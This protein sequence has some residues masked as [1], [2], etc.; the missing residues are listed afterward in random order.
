MQKFKIC[1]LNMAGNYGSL[2]IVFAKYFLYKPF[3]FLGS[4]LEP[5]WGWVFFPAYPSYSLGYSVFFN[6]GALQKCIHIHIKNQK[7]SRYELKKMTK[8]KK[9][10]FEEI[11]IFYSYPASYSYKAKNAQRFGNY[12]TIETFWIINCNCV[13][14]SKWVKHQPGFD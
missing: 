12:R 9:Y 13:V 3:R 8:M 1:S 2:Q 14:L 5:K 6:S 11:L 4:L 10:Y 7:L